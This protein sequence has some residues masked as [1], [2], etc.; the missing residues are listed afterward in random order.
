MQTPTLH[1]FQRDA[2]DQIKI[3]VR[4]GS[5]RPLLVAP[6]GAG[7]TV[8]FCHITA[9]FFAA[10]KTVFILVHRQELITQTSA[11]LDR[12]GIPHGVIDPSSS[13]DAGKLVHVCSVQTLV[14]R[15]KNYN[16]PDLI[17]VDEAHH[18]VAGTWKRI[19]DASATSL[20]LGVTATPE[21]LDG[22]GLK[23]VFDDLIR[24][25][26]VADLIEQGFLSRP[27]YWS[28][29][30]MDMSGKRIVM[31]DYKVADLEAAL[32]KRVMGDAV[33]TYRARADGMPAVAFCP[34]IA[35]A[36][37]VAAEFC[38]AGYRFAVIDGTLSKEVRRDMVES[39]LVGKLHGL[40]SCEIISEGFDVP[41]IGVAILLRPTDSLAV[42]LQQI[43]RALR[44]Y[45]G[46]QKA[47]ILD[48]AGNLHRH[49]LVEDF[50]DWS[51]DG[52]VAK[53][54]R[55]STIKEC[56]K[57]HAVMRVGIL[58]CSEC[59][60][61]FTPEIKPNKEAIKGELEQLT[62]TQKPAVGGANQEAA[63]ATS[64]QELQA[65]ARK[66]GYK[67][68]WAWHR[69]NARRQPIETPKFKYGF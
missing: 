29:P 52:G 50:R 67:Q 53:K 61:D 32:T 20:V 6:T 11:M 63:R 7:K 56:P 14:R 64:L 55:K 26:E 36:N 25:P 17:I 35:K 60:H 18:A 9:N 8:M 37:A 45:P 2:I 10:Q 62:A 47:V 57:C 42:H 23:G 4:A 19:L 39:L 5:R 30:S 15:L 24:G 22:A 69:W 59:G 1:P 40:C 58:Q 54:Q 38:D 65:I 16:A 46:K 48:H 43:G 41:T 68:G 44:T 33:A 21:R 66:Y 12:Y 28:H 13:Y 27:E 49:G 34:T 3:S 31:G 51:L